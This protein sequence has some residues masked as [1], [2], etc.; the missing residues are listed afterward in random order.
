MTKI[1]LSHALAALAISIPMIPASAE[2]AGTAIRGKFSFDGIANCE[3]PPVRN[4]PVH[5]EGTAEL[6]TDRNAR[7]DMNSNTE[8][9]VQL[10]ARLGDKPTEAPGGSASL[11]VAGKHTLRAIRDYPN[12]YIVVNLTVIGKSCSMKIENRLKPGKRQYT[13]HTAVGIAYCSKP[14]IIRAECTPY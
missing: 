12:N 8:G 14:Q 11:H 9:S 10:N 3:N 4:F 5:A 7:L 13:F 1:R 2:A 6:S